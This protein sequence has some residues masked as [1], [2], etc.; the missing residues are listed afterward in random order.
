MMEEWTYDSQFGDDDSD[1][2]DIAV[3]IYASCRSDRLEI[4][5]F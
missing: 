2:L 4:N 5:S 1:S 3:Y